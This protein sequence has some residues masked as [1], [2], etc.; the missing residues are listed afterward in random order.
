M[1]AAYTV[2]AGG[3]ATANPTVDCPASTGGGSNYQ[4]FATWAAPSGST[5][6]L[7]LEV[8][9]STGPNPI[10][11]TTEAANVAAFQT[12]SLSLTGT[13]ATRL[14]LQ[15]CSS[16]PSGGFTVNAT[17]VLT[18]ALIATK[19][20]AG[21][22]ARVPVAVCTYSIGAGSSGSATTVTSFASPG[23]VGSAG[24]NELTPFVTKNEGTINLP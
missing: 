5:V 18:G 13:A 24:G 14:S 3:T 22:T 2:T 21:A 17:N 19:T 16:P 7:T 15:G 11:G 1:P 20:G 12:G 6:K 8:D 23:L 10:P 9:P 4:Y